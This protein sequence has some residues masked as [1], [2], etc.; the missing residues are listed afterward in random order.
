MDSSY[1]S[2]Q[3]GRSWTSRGKELSGFKRLVRDSFQWLVDVLSMMHMDQNFGKLSTQQIRSY[4]L[5]TLIRSPEEQETF[6][7]A[8]VERLLATAR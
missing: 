8:S 3:D 5:G 6:S 2:S 7:F 1:A 4:P